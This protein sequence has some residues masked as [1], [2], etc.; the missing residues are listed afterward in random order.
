M[1]KNIC[2]NACFF[3][4]PVVF[5]G[6]GGN[7]DVDAADRAVFMLDGINGV[8][9]FEDVF[10]RVIDRVFTGFDGKALVSHILQGGHLA[11]DVLLG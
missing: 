7:V 4:F 10:D 1:K 8:D 11:D 2:T 9:T 3:E 5:H 6:G